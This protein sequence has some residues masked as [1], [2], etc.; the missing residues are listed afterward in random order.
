MRHKRLHFDENLV[1]CYHNLLYYFDL[2]LFSS[3]SFITPSSLPITSTYK[4]HTQTDIKVVMHESYK[5]LAN[6]ML[7]I[8]LTSID[9]FLGFIHAYSPPYISDMSVS[10]HRFNATCAK[11]EY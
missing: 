3:S 8:K 9:T 7:R 2:L 10:V 4:T 5:N 11:Y 6:D 1:Y